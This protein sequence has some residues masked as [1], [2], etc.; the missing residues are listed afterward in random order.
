MFFGYFFYMFKIAF[1]QWRAILPDCQ[2]DSNQV[3]FII[4]IYHVFTW[5]DMCIV[6]MYLKTNFKNAIKV[7]YIRILFITSRWQNKN[8]L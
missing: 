7:S 3:S 6:I 4:A 1:E 2:N 5:Y 8:P